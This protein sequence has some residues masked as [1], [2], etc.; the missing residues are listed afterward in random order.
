MVLY[1]GTP[2]VEPEV[3]LAVERVVLQGV[4]RG[5]RRRL[6]E[7]K[8]RRRSVAMGTLRGASPVVAVAS[9]S[10]RKGRPKGSK[11]RPKPDAPSMDVSPTP[12]G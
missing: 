11:N 4:E 10:K 3:L 7:M 9:P 2:I 6:K 12:G 5:I 1:N 8:P